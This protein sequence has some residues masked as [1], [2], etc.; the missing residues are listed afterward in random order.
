[1]G[2]VFWVLFFVL[3]AGF[4]W[5]FSGRRNNAQTIRPYQK[6]L[7]QNK[8]ILS[9]HFS[10]YRSLPRKSRIIF[11]RR[12]ERFIRLTQFVPREMSH[13]SDEMKV[14]ISAS[15]VQITFGYNDVLLDHF[16]KTIPD[17]TKQTQ[18]TVFKLRICVED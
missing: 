7:Q 12:V 1:M 14:L 10:F 5:H 8:E 9:Q 16:S 4:I 11:V 2:L 17:Q 18:S 15:A 6:A 3:A 13:V